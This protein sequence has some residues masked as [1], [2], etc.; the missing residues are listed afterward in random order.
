MK[1]LDVKDLEISFKDKKVVKGISFDIGEGD[2]FALV[3]ESGSGKSVT[4][5][6]ILRLLPSS[7]QIKGSIKYKN[8]EINWEQ[9][10]KLKEI[11]GKEIGYIPQNPITSLN[12]VKSIYSQIKETV[13]LYN[14]QLDKLELFIFCKNLLADVQL[15]DFEKVFQSYPFELSGGMC[16]RIMIAMALAGKPKLLL[17]DEPTTALDV[18]IQA[19]I[20]TLL[21]ETTKKKGLSLLL[22]THDLPLVA[23]TCKRVAV[24]KDG[25]I[26]EYGSVQD[27][28]TQP[29]NAYTKSLL[30]S[31]K[32]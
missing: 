19:E 20:M 27:I 6:S 24:I 28:F 10:N 18:T 11:R 16:Q 8:I 23:Q 32:L 25:E 17:A 3:G 30:D 22:I 2:T 13:E 7:A 1:I 9:F 4:C 14:P 15:Y 5:S 12:P 21:L 31:I 26:Q 29:Q